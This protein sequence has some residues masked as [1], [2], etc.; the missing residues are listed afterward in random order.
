MEPFR[1]FLLESFDDGCGPVRGSVIDD[2]NVIPSFERENFTD[3]VFDVF[4]LVVCRD[5]DDFSV[6]HINY[7]WMLRK[8]FP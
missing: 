5:N 1:E 2:E 8:A 7:F 4:S 6:F 3:D